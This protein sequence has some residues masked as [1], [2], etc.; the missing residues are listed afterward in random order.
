[1]YLPQYKLFTNENK[2]IFEFTS[3][4]VKGSILKRVTYTKMS[5]PNLYNLRVCEKITDTF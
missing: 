3:I 5:D 4:G 1:M 2:N